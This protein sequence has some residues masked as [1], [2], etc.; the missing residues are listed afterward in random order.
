M[1]YTPGPWLV[2]KNQAIFAPNGIDR[3]GKVGF[4]VAVIEGN[5]ADRGG[6]KICPMLIS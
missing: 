6:G 2:M 1:T 3:N 5:F 4:D